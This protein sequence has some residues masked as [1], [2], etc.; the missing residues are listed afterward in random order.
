[1]RESIHVTSMLGCCLVVLVSAGGLAHA[2]KIRLPLEATGADPL[3]SGRVDFE[4]RDDR[5]KLSIE[6]ED[7]SSATSVTFIVGGD[8]LG[9]LAVVVGVADLNLDSRI[10]DTVPPVTSETAVQVVNADTS[11]LILFRNGDTG[12]GEGDGDGPED[13]L[14]LCLAPTDAEPLASGRA[15]FEVRPDRERLTIEVEGIETATT[16]DFSV[17]GV[18]IGSAA[19]TLGIA[20]LRLDS[21]IGD[22]VPTIMPDT[23][24]EV[25]DANTS[26]I[27]LTTIGGGRRCDFLD[28]NPED[29]LEI[30]FQL[31]AI[32]L[33]G[34]ALG[35]GEAELRVVSRSGDDFFGDVLRTDSVRFT[36]EVEDMAPST[37]FPIT[38]NGVPAGSITTDAVG[39]GRVQFASVVEAG[40]DALPDGFPTD[41]MVGD[42][43]TVGD[44]LSGAFEEKFERGDLNQDG[45]VD[46][47]D[48]QLLQGL[49][50]FAGPSAADLNGD[51][52][53][54]GQDR[55]I[56]FGVVGLP[57]NT[58]LV[59]LGS[60]LL[61]IAAYV[62]TLR[63]RER[64]I[65]Q[66]MK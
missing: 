30:E 38:I 20:V 36:V 14:R 8:E 41:V 61:L 4:V 33:E 44:V 19:V 60:C 37:T 29:E 21:R 50:G 58:L 52:I 28:D 25:R 57:L 3:A 63:R 9:T 11:E 45:T 49:I 34:R 59:V 22:T 2:E 17:E 66:R 16:L 7:I 40:D 39:D 12:D 1:M 6:V 10:G 18:D 64:A 62:H 42:I 55:N 26:D 15:K 24:I 46:E 48:V 31:R 56:I 53:V 65:V 54:D 43:V 13:E 47:T 23:L 32:L 51:G 5:V 35:H 27:V